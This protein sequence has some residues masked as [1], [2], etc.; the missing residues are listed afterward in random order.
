[1]CFSIRNYKIH[2]RFIRDERIISK[3]AEYGESIRKRRCSKL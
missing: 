1:M 3:V 2:F